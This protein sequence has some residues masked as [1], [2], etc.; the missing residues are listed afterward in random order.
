[1]LRVFIAWTETPRYPILDTWEVEYP[2]VPERT[3]LFRI[4]WHHPYMR[5]IIIKKESHKTI[6]ARVTKEMDAP[7]MAKSAREQTTKTPQMVIQHAQ[8]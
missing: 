5:E 4:R 2:P 6:L 8:R 3:L 1:L 7:R